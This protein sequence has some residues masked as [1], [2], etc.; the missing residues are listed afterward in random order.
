MQI[1]VKYFSGK[2]ITLEVEPW[3]RIED[4]K[5]KIC[6]KELIPPDILLLYFNNQK[7]KD[8]IT[9]EYYSIK[10]D[11]TLCAIFNPKG[12][13]CASKFPSPVV[14]FLKNDHEKVIKPL[15]PGKLTSRFIRNT[16]SSRV[17]EQIG[18]TCYAYAACSAYINTILRICGSKEPPSFA[19][20]FRIA[21]YNGD[22]GGIP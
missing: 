5:A 6:D 1:F 4:V 21:C 14:G 12:G 18:G 15:K 17:Y 22:K 11:C 16:N 2:F 3:D 13:C 10:P 8:G 9:L 20:C 7:L 19:E